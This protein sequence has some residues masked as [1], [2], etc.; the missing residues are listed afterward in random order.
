[1]QELT[2]CARV[3]DYLHD[4]MERSIYSANLNQ[5]ALYN[6]C[7]L[8]RDHG[9]EESLRAVSSSSANPRAGAVRVRRHDQRFLKR[10]SSP[11]RQ[12]L[13]TG[14]RCT[15]EWARG[16]LYP[17]SHLPFPKIP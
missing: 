2:H 14:V 3:S 1:M 16:K 7:Q 13:A 12:E 6:R 5:V 17:G 9:I 8:R 15:V 4:N 10:V 11:P